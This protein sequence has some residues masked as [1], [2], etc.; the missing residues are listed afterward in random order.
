[1]AL[2]PLRVLSL[3]SG[4]GGL[5]LGIRL[6]V[7]GSRT[8]GFVER[9]AF[10]AACLVARMEEQALDPAPVWDDLTTFEGGAWRGRV[11][12]VAAG[13]PCQPW[14]NAGQRRGT[15]DE[16][17]LW[18]AVAR[19]VRE[20]GPRYVFLENVRGL[21][22]G[23]IEH[24]LGSLAELGFD[25]EWD[26]F[27]ASDVGAPHQRARVFLL[28]RAVSDADGGDLREPAERRV[29]GEAERRDAVAGDVGEGLADAACGELPL[30]RRRSGDR[31]GPLPD[32]E[33][34]ADAH[35]DRRRECGEAHDERGKPPGDVHDGRDPSLADADRAR[36]E[37]RRRDVPR[38]NEG[39][40]R[41]SSPAVGDADGERHGKEGAARERAT[42]AREPSDGFWPPGPDDAEGWRRWLEG[43][44]GTEP[45]VRRGAHGVARRVVES[46]R[47]DRLRGLGNGVVPLC[48]A[49]ALLTLDERLAAHGSGG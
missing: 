24:V 25:A 45:A 34:V 41:T 39:A 5:D 47:A 19:V 2:R 38:P 10:A 15:D 13:F 29:R 18:P 43:H 7:P 21:L 42:D 48:A 32:G 27:R 46:E 28:A 40:A 20:V 31:S 4:A 36:L 6:A 1:M 30:A 11:D 22:R 44:P 14:S 3:C 12:L 17:W 23:G 35:H 26:V 49:V 8:V 16:R 37:R 9:D 33:D